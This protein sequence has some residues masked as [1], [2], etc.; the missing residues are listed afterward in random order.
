M[1]ETRRDADF[2]GRG[3]P[4]ETSMVRNAMKKGLPG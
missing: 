1:Q 3:G 4:P 2:L